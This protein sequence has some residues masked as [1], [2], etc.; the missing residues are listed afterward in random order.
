MSGITYSEIKEEFLKNKIGL[1]GIGI[2]AG[3][4]ILSGI[5][6][7]TIPIDTFKQWN[8]PNNW[9][10]Y[11]KTSLPAWTNYFVVEKIPMQ[12]DPEPV[13]LDK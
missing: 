4:V 3:L 1:I 5:A 7:I 10:S 13:I 8:N 2:L 11:P 6:V 12:A 9:I